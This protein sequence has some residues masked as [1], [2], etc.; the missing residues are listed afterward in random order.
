MEQPDLLPADLMRRVATTHLGHLFWGVGTRVSRA[1][2]Q[3]LDGP[4]FDLEFD[5]NHRFTSPFSGADAQR[6]LALRAGEFPY[7][8]SPDGKWLAIWDRRSGGAILVRSIHH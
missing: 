4:P 6:L 2:N 7:S 1:R 5:G 8:V 3:S